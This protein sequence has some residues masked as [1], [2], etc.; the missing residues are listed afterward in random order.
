M[1]GDD[2]IAGACGINAKMN[3]LVPNPKSFFGTN[4][5]Q[6]VQA[7]NDTLAAPAH[8]LVHPTNPTLVYHPDLRSH[9]R[10]YAERKEILHTLF[11]GPL[12]AER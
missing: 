8:T 3:H 9:V 1:P 4:P 7:G 6:P 10:T 11:Y 5:M 2:V 12:G